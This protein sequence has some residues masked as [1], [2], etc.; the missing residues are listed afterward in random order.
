MAQAQFTKV[1]LSG[2]AN[3]RNVLVVATSSPGTTIH[4]ATSTSGAMDELWLWAMN[5]DTSDR[6]L[7]IE[8]GG[9]TAPND[10]IELTMPAESGLIPIV[11]GF[12]LDGGVI[13][14][15]FCATGNV[16][17]VNG[18]VNRIST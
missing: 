10:L 11:P 7:T 16:V 13:V 9:T 14:K 4:T 5:T 3:G 6:K 17:T 1:Q 12:P 18:F 15:A 2:G 8:L